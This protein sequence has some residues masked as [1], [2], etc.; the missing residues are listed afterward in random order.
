MAARHHVKFALGRAHHF[1]DGLGRLYAVNT[2]GAVLGVL[3]AGFVLL[4]VLGETGSLLVAAV[5]NLLA[6]TAHPAS[7]NGSEPTTDYGSTFA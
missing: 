5:A 4:G 2:L 3:A 6:A 1:Q 7:E